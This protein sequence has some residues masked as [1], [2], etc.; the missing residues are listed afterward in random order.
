MRQAPAPQSPEPKRTYATVS[1]DRLVG[2]VLGPV[3]RRRG[4]AE[5]TILAEWGSVVGPL[6]AGRCQPMR[7]DFPRGRA[8]G[9]TL[10]LHARGGAAL[11]IQHLAPQLVERVNRYF[12]FPAVRRIRLVQSPP[13]AHRRVSVK[14]AAPPLAPEA[15]LS[16]RRSVGALADEPLGQA[17]L[18]LG[19]MVLSS[20]TRP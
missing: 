18:A 17:L 6:L 2:R 15:E 4:F 9:G 13:T 5:A 11:E 12:G 14:V 3:A 16:L 1:V 20:R 7:V 8:Q 10:E 19:R